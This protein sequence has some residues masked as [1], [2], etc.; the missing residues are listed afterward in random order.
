MKRAAPT[1]L[2]AMVTVV[3]L[4]ASAAA[5]PAMGGPVRGGGSTGG[6]T[7]IVDVSVGDNLPGGV[8][9]AGGNRPT[10]RTAYAGLVTEY[11]RGPLPGNGCPGLGAEMPGST[12][13]PNNLYELV[14]HDRT[15]EPPTITVLQRTCFPPETAPAVEPAPPPAPP[16]LGEITAVAQRRVVAPTVGISPDLDGLTGLETWFWYQGE[17]E[18]TVPTSIR[19]YSVTATMH[20]ARFL[21]YTGE[22]LLGSPVPGSPTAPAARWVYETKG[23]YTV[24]VQAVWEGTWSF[25]GWGASASGDL[26]TIR[27]TGSRP[28]TV[29][30]VRSVL[31]G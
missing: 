25:T 10:A 14:Q 18:F 7:V 28:Y 22:E 9:G 16:T 2:T 21:W 29:N 15:T 24:Y 11:W 1:L 23:G 30:E 27:A 26:A 12:T 19:G 3:L 17:S 8:G 5:Q 31:T 6:D 20:V 4:A 13:A